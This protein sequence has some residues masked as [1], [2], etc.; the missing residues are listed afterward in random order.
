MPEKLTILTEDAEVLGRAFSAL[1]EEWG[2]ARTP[3]L[4]QLLERWSRFVR[5]VEDGYRLTLDDYTLELS[6]RDELESV[7]DQLSLELRKQILGALICWDQRLTLATN[8]MDQPLVPG[9]EQGA[10]FW[11]FSVP[12]R[13]VGELEQDLLSLG[14]PWK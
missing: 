7:V 13:L 3:S 10:S 11:W 9:V 2:W 5:D 14:L 6:I 8:L 4:E 12:R 1:R